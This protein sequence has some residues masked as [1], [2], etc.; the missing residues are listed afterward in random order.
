MSVSLVYTSAGPLELGKRIGRGGEGEVY[1]VADGSGRVVKLY[2]NPDAERQA[3]VGAMINAGLAGRCPHAAFPLAAVH[4]ADKKFAGFAMHG[5]ADRQPLHQLYSPGSRRKLFPAADFRFLVRSALNLAR[6]VSKVH[7]A[8]VVI[9]DINHSSMLV[10]SDARVALI[11]ADSMQVGEHRCRVGV[12]EYTPPELQGRPLGGVVRTKAHDAFGLAV[13]LF[14]M[15]FLGRHPYAG[16]TRREMP[17]AQAIATHRF[18]WSRIFDNGVT[19][20]PNSLLLTDM[21]VHVRVAFERAFGRDP[22]ARP[23]ASAWAMALAELEQLLVPCSRD[24]HHHRLL[25]MA[26]VWCR[27]ERNGTSAI[28]CRCKPSPGSRPTTEDAML[29][30]A[31]H[32]LHKVRKLLAKQLEPAGQTN[33]C[34]PSDA[35]RAFV[36]NTP[37]E[38]AE[39][40]LNLPAGGVVSQDRFTCAYL[41]SR[42]ELEASLSAWRR[43]I[44]LWDLEALAAKIELRMGELKRL[45]QLMVDDLV[46]ASANS[47]AAFVAA[48]L[49]A[50]KLA[51]A[52]IPGISRRRLQDVAKQFKAATDI[53]KHA[54]LRAPGL[55]P[56]RVA[57]LLLWR[58]EV[59]S[60]AARAARIRYAAEPQARDSGRENARVRVARCREKLNREIVEAKLL[61][62][63]IINDVMLVAPRVT[64]ARKAVAARHADIRHLGLPLP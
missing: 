4:N 1:A 56:T 10:G 64:A 39:L 6:S 9:G 51:D 32:E 55:G 54:L 17:L 61:R 28:F 23:D 7:D 14:Q 35:V 38:H 37:L 53:N 8:G 41:R 24:P 22:R 19:P 40:K 62:K 20:P 58:D 42:D 15:L 18:A 44:G 43:R 11:D 47:R 34:P 5:F 52:T 45:E 21:P 30:S 29:D 12:P 60:Q 36:Q 26:C 31:Q 3:K 33:W 25:D 13:L 49:R 63:K 27:V 50:A 59:E 48:A 57:A 16:V 46:S 2:L